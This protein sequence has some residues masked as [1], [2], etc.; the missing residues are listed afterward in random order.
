MF[1]A[2]DHTVEV[3]QVEL[4]DFCIELRIEAD[5]GES[6]FWII[7]VYASTDSRERQ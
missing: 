7:M 3:K 4:H 5:E 1:V 6:N 2:W